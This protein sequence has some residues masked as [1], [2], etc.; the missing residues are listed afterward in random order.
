MPPLVVVVSTGGTIA[1]R[2]DPS[3]GKLVPAVSGEELVEMLDWPEAP[4]LELD[5]FARVPS[6]D[7]HGEFALSLAVR[8]SEQADRQDVADRKST[9][10]NSSHIQKSRMPSSA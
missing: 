2:P 8:V 4:P 3:T 7:V 9:R 6:F 10:L 1:M 5:D